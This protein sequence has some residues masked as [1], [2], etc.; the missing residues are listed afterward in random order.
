MLQSGVIQP[1]TSEWASPVC[2]VRK[3]DG[4]FRFCIDYRRVN[5]VSRRDAFPVPEVQD[6]LDSL[7][8]SQYFATLDLLSGYWQLGMTDR[9]RERS[10]FCTRRGLFEFVRM[11]FG[12][13]GAPATFCRVM[14]HV[15]S[16]YLW[17]ICLCYIDDLIIFGHTQQELLERLDLVLTRLRD[18]WS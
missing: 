10:A 12:L 2:L 17:K 4:S 7:R 16:D 6:A 11:P 8:G 15:M 1:S 13:S 14:S 3:P 18:L 9:A 5:A